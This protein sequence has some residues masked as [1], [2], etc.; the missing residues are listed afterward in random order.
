MPLPIAQRDDVVMR[1]VKQDEVEAAA[2]VPGQVRAGQPAR[3]EDAPLRRCTATSYPASS[4]KV[5]EEV[6]TAV[7]GNAAAAEE[8]AEQIDAA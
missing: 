8:E 1:A 4:V 3:R 7:Q 2:L 5:V 6:E